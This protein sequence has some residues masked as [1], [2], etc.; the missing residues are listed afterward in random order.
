M[1]YNKKNIIRLLIPFLVLAFIFSCKKQSPPPKM[2]LNYFGLT[3]GRYVIYDVKEMTHDVALNPQ[4]D[5]LTYQLKTLI[6]DEHIDDQGRTA[7]EFKRYKRSTDTDAWVL[8][9]IWTTIIENFKAELIEE[10]QRIIKLVFSP[11]T[12]KNW[13]PNV[14]NSFDSTNYYYT[15]IHKPMTINNLSFDSTLTVQQA[16]FKSL[17]DYQN[18]Y[19]VYATNIG[20]VSKSYKNLKIANFDTLDVKKGNEI[21]YKCVSFGIE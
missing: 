9:D 4:H 1:I 5:T 14:F 3:P 10:N 6:G 18:Q 20:L 11:T 19:E 21:H 8:T 2:H 13:N 17:I 15:G 12:D 7:R 16:F